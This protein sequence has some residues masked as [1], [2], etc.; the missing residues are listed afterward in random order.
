MQLQ[1]PGH[2][3]KFDGRLYELSLPPNYL[4]DGPCPRGLII[5]WDRPGIAAMWALSP[6]LSYVLLQ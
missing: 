3:S 4:V 5:P 1:L 6:P 2:E